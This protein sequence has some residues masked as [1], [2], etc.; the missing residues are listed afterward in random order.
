MSSACLSRK[1]LT[2][3]LEGQFEPLLFL[4]KSDFKSLIYFFISYL[5]RLYI[6]DREMKLRAVSS[7]SS[8]IR[9]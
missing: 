7:S 9:T 6:K 1:E 8:L 2:L 3:T 4:V 5:S